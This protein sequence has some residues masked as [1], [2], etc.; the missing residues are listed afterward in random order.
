MTELM[1]DDID[2]QA[3]HH[4][5]L[6]HCVS[7]IDNIEPLSP[8][9]RTA[10]LSERYMTPEMLSHWC[11]VVDGT[12]ETTAVQAMDEIAQIINEKNLA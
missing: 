9:G 11:E 4:V 2:E 8:S 3:A 10:W 5:L 12:S 1:I 7:I 6:H